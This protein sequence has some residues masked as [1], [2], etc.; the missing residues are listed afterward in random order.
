MFRKYFDGPPN[1]RNLARDCRLY[2][3][4]AAAAAALFR[5]QRIR[6]VRARARVKIPLESYTRTRTHTIR[7]GQPDRRIQVYYT[8]E[9]ERERLESSR[10]I[11]SGEPS[12]DVSRSCCYAAAAIRGRKAAAHL[13]SSLLFF[14][15]CKRQWGFL[16]FAHVYPRCHFSFLRDQRIDIIF[17]HLI[18]LRLRERK[19]TIDSKLISTQ[20]RTRLIETNRYARALD[21][22]VFDF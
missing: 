11:W 10:L 7:D 14:L 6:A 16:S 22:L 3:A 13:D 5:A 1:E 9:K 17:L 18:T 2:S 12:S 15:S 8:R 21:R 4:A 19:A 20:P